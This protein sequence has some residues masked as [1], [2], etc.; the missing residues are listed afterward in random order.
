MELR[1]TCVTWVIITTWLL[2]G[3]LVSLIHKM[4]SNKIFILTSL[5]VCTFFAFFFAAIGRSCSP[6]TGGNI[7]FKVFMNALQEMLVCRI[8]NVKSLAII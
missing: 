8:I 2:R 3:D 6:L 5:A 7:S 4:I 1:V